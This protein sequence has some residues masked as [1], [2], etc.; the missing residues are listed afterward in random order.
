MLSS[1][2]AALVTVVALTLCA[3][4]E[5]DPTGPMHRPKAD[6][7]A[8]HDFVVVQL[9]HPW[10]FTDISAG[11]F[12]T[13]ASRFDGAL[14]CW[15]WNQTGQVGTG[16]S[17][18]FGPF[19]SP[20]CSGFFCVIAPTYVMG[21]VSEVEAGSNHTCAIT[22]ATPPV[23]GGNAECWGLGSSGELGNGT[24]NLPV[25]EWVTG[26]ISFRHISAGE[27]SAC[28]T[29]ALGMHCW[30]RI[31]GSTATPT[32]IS[33]SNAYYQIAVGADYGCAVWVSSVKYVDCWGAN[34]EGQTGQDPSAVLSPQ[35]IMTAPLGSA[36]VDV[37][38]SS[39]F[40]CA[41]Q[42]SG[43]V[44]CFGANNWGQLGYGLVPSPG[45]PD[46]TYQVKAVNEGTFCFTSLFGGVRCKTPPAQLH[47]VSV[48]WTHGCGLDP[49]GYAYCW[50]LN[51]NGQLGIDSN[52]NWSYAVPVVGG[53]TF[54]AIAVGL[55]HT[56][57]IGTDNILYCW[58]DNSVGQLGNYGT[59]GQIWHPTPTAAL[60]AHTPP[61]PRNNA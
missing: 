25:P 53:H 3:C 36:V 27:R 44:N 19:Q 23:G 59:S 6:S 29:S 17:D 48:G 50:G 28:G 51:D 13:C 49:N 60:R 52:A 39:G 24:S 42:Q 33:S 34:Y 22:W 32:L 2:K 7:A 43:V 26:G 14:Y 10:D 12:H 30:G 47:G 21:S 1:T 5:K 61:P 35:P 54:R 4:T 55:Q 20:I 11:A 40:T 9:P 56:C 41:D 57:A 58:G 15:G 45:S 38:V 16:E 8:R 46:Y 37:A 31:Q 18:P